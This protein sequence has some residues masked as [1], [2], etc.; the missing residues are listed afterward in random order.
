M[1]F[2]QL[3]VS[4]IATSTKILY[5]TLKTFRR[6]RRTSKLHCQAQYNKDDPAFDVHIET[7]RLRVLEERLFPDNFVSGN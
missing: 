6:M 5:D 4:R 3:R 1:V 7:A 2:Q